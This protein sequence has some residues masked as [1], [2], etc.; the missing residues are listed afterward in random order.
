[1]RGKNN[2]SEKI[3]FSF[4]AI[5]YKDFIAC[6][7]IVCARFAAVVFVQITCFHQVHSD[8]LKQG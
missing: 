8:F 5:L 2:E 4:C 6:H 3:Q 1:M 7:I